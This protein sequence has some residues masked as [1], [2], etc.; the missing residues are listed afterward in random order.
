MKLTSLRPMIWV[1]D[2]KSTIRYYTGVPGFEQ[3]H[4]LSNWGWGFVYLDEVGFM[5]A[6]P[7]EHFPIRAC[8]SRVHS[9]EYRQC[10]RL[11]A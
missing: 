3:G 6:K 8:S 5:F 10:N 4:H 7:M 2:V 11:V 1:E 9:T